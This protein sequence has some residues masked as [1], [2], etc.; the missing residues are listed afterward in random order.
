MEQ[1]ILE[2]LNGIYPLDFIKVEAVT[3]EMFRCTANQGEYFARITNYK[4]YDEQLEEVTYTNYLYKEGLGVSPT[5]VSINGKVVEKITFN[6]NEVLTILYKSALGKHLSK[7]QWNAKVLKELGRQIGKL[8]RISRTFEEINPTRYINDWYQNEEY[9]FLKYIPEEESTIRDVA[10]EI[11]TKIK[12]IPKDNSNYGLL[13]GDLW[14]ENILVDRNL[15]LSMV[16]FQDCEKNFYIFDLAVPIYS[17]IEYS[18]VGGGNIIEYGRGIAKAIIEGY[19]EENDLPKDMLDKLPL[20]IKLKEVF[21]YS[22]MHMYWNKERLTEEQIRIMNHFR[23]RIEKNHS[24]LD[25]DGL[26]II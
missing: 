9:A 11:L 14:L 1:K 23:M 18:F 20:F 16:D 7:N 22:L 12:N 19:Q 8:H 13:H 25:T 21:E 17:A 10:Q 24:F 15:K 5:I 2:L 3:N 26:L 4:G 6:N